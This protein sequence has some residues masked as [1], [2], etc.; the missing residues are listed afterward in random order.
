MEN[1]KAKLKPDVGTSIQV[2][3]TV[4]MKEFK[5]DMHKVFKY[6]IIT[7]FNIQMLVFC[8]KAMVI[9][10]EMRT[11]TVPA[12]SGQMTQRVFTQIHLSRVRTNMEIE[13]NNKD[14]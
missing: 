7:M 5:T 4:A 2:Q 8:Q 13:F 11:H 10:N 6:T 9:F 3:N 14:K 12:Y 1:L